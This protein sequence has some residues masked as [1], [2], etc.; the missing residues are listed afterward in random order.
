[1]PIDDVRR[2]IERL[3]HKLSDMRVLERLYAEKQPAEEVAPDPVEAQ[4]P[5]DPAETPAPDEPADSLTADEPADPPASAESAEPQ[6]PAEPTE[7]HSP[8]APIGSW[9]PSDGPGAP[10]EHLSQPT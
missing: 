2:R 9:T 3:E 7:L 8:P 6:A 10:P 5:S 4:A 1:M